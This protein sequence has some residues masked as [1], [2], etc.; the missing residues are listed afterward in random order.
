MINTDNGDKITAVNFLTILP[1]K[2]DMEIVLEYML[3]V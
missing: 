2:H 1:E 3:F